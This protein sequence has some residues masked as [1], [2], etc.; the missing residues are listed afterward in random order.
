MLL[1]T[2]QSCYGTPDTLVQDFW[3]ALC[4]MLHTRAAPAAES[5]V[6]ADKAAAA[7]GGPPGGVAPD[8]E[9]PNE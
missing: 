1:T 6:P 5:A 8:S 7:Q 3:A 2:P 9:V 4:A